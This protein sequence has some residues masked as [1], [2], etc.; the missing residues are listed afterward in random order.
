MNIRLL[1]VLALTVFVTLASAGA[2]D[3]DA[4][5]SGSPDYDLV[6]K[7]GHVIDAKNHIDEVFDVAIKD[8]KIAAVAKDIP[9]EYAVKSVMVSGMYVTPGLIDIHTHVY[10]GT[11]ERNSYAGDLSVYPDGFTL[12]NG[13]TTIVDAGSSGWRSFPDFKD[14][15]I[16]RSQTRVL[17]M[18]NIVGAGMRGG[19]YENNLADM[20]AEPTAAMAL[21]YPG[22]IVGIKSAHFA[23]PEWTPYE[24]AVKAGNIAHIPV[25]IDFGVRRTERPLC[26]L[27]ETVL[28]PGDIYTHAFS[29]ERG[30]QDF[31]T[32]GPG[33]GMREGRARGIYFDV[34]HGQ[35]SFAWF[36]AIPLYRAGFAPDS[37]ST[38][39]HIDSMNAG[40]KDMLNIGDKYLAI[41]MP[42]QEVVR[43]MTWNPAREILQTQLGNLSVG[44]IADV[45][46]ISL[47]HGDFGFDDA[48]STRVKGTE[49]MFC[50]LT[51]KDGKVIYDLNAISGEPWDTP[52]GRATREAKR[53]TRL[54]Q[55]GMGDSQW[56][57]G[58]GQPLIKDWTPYPW[59]EHP[60][61]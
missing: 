19:K 12:R 61:Q 40:M 35:A 27:L 4:L 60:T 51:I 38:D 14:R 2:Q 20:Q 6:L 41:G 54:R 57:P 3:K 11:G 49:K 25:M 8:G 42:L 15:V 13:V 18:L 5:P 53:W 46:V 33:C 32:G 36:T 10:A 48:Y 24:Q 7:G 58:P 43:D 26:Q 9:A 39:L 21:K 47:Q 34:G 28:R 37:I 29:G 52:P 56:R 16:D 55:R 45:A 17:A 31:K 59:P 44:A 50:E 30:E 22:V 1:R 23:G